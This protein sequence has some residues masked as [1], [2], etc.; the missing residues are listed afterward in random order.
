[1]TGNKTISIGVKQ[2]SVLIP[3]IKDT[4]IAANSYL[5][6]WGGYIVLESGDEVVVT[7]TASDSGDVFSVFITVEEETK[8][9]QT[10]SGTEPYLVP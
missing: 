5:H 9:S 7:A 1:M 8:Q 6:I 3:F 10:N 2:D 4:T